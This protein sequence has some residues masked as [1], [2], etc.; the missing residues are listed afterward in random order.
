MAVD[1]AGY[2]PKTIPN[3]VI[4]DDVLHDVERYK[5]KLGEII[6]IT[7][8]KVLEEWSKLAMADV[9][10]GTD[11]C[12]DKI[13]ALDALSRHLGLFSRDRQDTAGDLAKGLLDAIGRMT[14]KAPAIDTVKTSTGY[15]V[16][17]AQDAP[18]VPPA[19]YVPSCP[20][21]WTASLGQDK[22]KDTQSD[23]DEQEGDN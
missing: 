13:K 17:P 7:P 22:P 8:S 19:P 9:S 5:R 11:A 16:A 18:T 20:G 4:N 21:G 1:L 6:D 3:S 2:S 14:G 10:I 23:E 15:Q 12:R